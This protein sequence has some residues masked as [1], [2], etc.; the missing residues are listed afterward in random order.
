MLTVQVVGRNKSVQRKDSE[1][2]VWRHVSDRIM[3]RELFD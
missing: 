1:V 2:N 3:L